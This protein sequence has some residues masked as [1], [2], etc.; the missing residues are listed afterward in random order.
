[1]NMYFIETLFRSTDCSVVLVVAGITDRG[2]LILPQILSSRMGRVS[3]SL[4]E[5]DMLAV[6]ADCHGYVAADIV[7]LCR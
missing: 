1:M 7:R 5:Q 3:H 2:C 4:S 6:A